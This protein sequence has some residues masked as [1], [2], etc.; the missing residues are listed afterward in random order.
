MLKL[1]L[2][3]F[4]IIGLLLPFSSLA[5][6]LSGPIVPCGWG[7]KP[8]CTLCHFFVMIQNIVDFI[9][10]AVFVLAPVF[11]LIGGI[12]ILVSTG[13]P[14]RVSLGRKIITSAI[15][16]LVI[17]LLS[18]TILNE[19]LIALNGFITVEGKKV[20]KIFD[21]PWN[22]IDCEGGG[23]TGEEAT[24]C[25]LQYKNQPDVMTMNYSSGIE[26][27][28]ECP[29]LCDLVIP[30]ELCEAWCCLGE[31]KDGQDNV[32]GGVVAGEW[33][34]RPAPAGSDKWILNPPPG[35]ADERQKGD[36]SPRLAS[37]LN[38]M[39]GKISNLRINSISHNIL[40][41]NP[42]CDITSYSCGHTANSCHFGG[43]KC[44]GVSYAVD[45]DTNVD[46]SRINQ[47][48]KECDSTAWVNWESDHTHVSLNRGVCGCD[49]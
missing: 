28:Q 20:G 46:Y 18:W 12:M 31:N 8:D 44:T 39:Y 38:C 37:F 29:K 26:C 23:T 35:G 15:I 1:F 47:Y 48:A 17:A 30:R 41:S 22:E 13:V 10:A 27:I 9:L 49:E 45:F 14:D 11:V 16:G 40:C 21:W 33:C 19:F 43:T 3:I 24:Y 6:N 42:Y 32:C 34:Q 25:H 5:G 4:I 2:S 7:D 36:A